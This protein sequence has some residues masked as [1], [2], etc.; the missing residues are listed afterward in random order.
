MKQFHGSHM[1]S[2][3][4]QI[5]YIETIVMQIRNTYAYILYT[6]MLFII[7]R[8]IYCTMYKIATKSEVQV[9]V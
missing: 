1:F 8:I 4:T 7:L 2:V 9:L 6:L 5:Q 3:A